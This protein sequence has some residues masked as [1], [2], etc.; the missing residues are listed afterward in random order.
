[1][2]TADFVL[3]TSGNS[4]FDQNSLWQLL[5]NLDDLFY[6]VVPVWVQLPIDF[7]D[8]LFNFL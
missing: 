6:E 3:Q 5:L 4:E 7:K 8:R 2:T 1:M